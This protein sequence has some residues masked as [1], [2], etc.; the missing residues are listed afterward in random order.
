[1][2]RIRSAADMEVNL[3]HPYLFEGYNLYAHDGQGK[4][5]R[6]EHEMLAPE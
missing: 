2:D 4:F 5:V 1:M 3:S 6:A